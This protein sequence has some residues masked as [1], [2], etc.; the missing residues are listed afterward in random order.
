MISMVAVSGILLLVFMSGRFLKYL[1][2]AAQGSISASMT[3]I[4]PAAVAHNATRPRF[5]PC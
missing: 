1:D 2:S 5:R 3:R 4:V